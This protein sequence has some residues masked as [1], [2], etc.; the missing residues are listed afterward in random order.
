MK[1]LQ[2][3]TQQSLILAF[4][5]PFRCDPGGRRDDS[6]STS[7]VNSCL[8]ALPHRSRTARFGSLLATFVSS[9]SPEICGLPNSHG[10]LPVSQLRL[11]PG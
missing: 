2:Q 6:P 10:G 1:R 7:D 11:L 9:A 5:E 3:D 8:N 4:S